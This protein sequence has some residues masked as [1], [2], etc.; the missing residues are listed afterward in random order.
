MKRTQQLG[1][2]ARGKPAH[3]EMKKAQRRAERRE[4]KRTVAKAAKGRSPEVIADEFAKFA[5][6]R[7]YRYFGW[8]D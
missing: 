7:G 2:L 8:D 1:Q 4:R 3:G 6:A 5:A